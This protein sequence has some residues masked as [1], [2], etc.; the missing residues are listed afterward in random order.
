MKKIILL[1]MLCCGSLSFL[2]AQSETESPKTFGSNKFM[3]T[4]NGEAVF[5]SDS[6]SANFTNINFK[7]IF[8]WKLSDKLFIESEVEIET[9]DGVA[10]LGLEYV[11]MCYIVNPYL[12]FHMGRFLP[13]FGAYRG[14]LGEAYINRFATNPIGFGD[15]GIGPM[16]EVGFGAQGGVPLGSAKMNY[17]LW[18]SNGPQ[19]GKDEATGETA[20][21]SFDYEA[22]SDNNKN[23]ALGGRIGILPFSNSSLEL[24]FSYENAQKTGDSYSPFED[25]S[26]NMMAVDLNYFHTIIAI[27]STVR[28]I[29][30]WK[31]QDEKYPAV[32]PTASYK[33][34]SS[35]YYG[36]ISIRPSVL[37]NKF[38]RN[39]ELAYRYSQF[40]L[41]KVK[42][43]NE[44]A[45]LNK[46]DRM[47]VALDYWFKWNCV[48]KVMWQK[49]KDFTNQYLVQ[50]V[51]GF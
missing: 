22:Y 42:L 37:E 10:D 5:T 15:G 27:K 21:G 38:L 9:G 51:Y 7:P 35:T 11:N 1:V 50:V 46:P 49:E 8:L 24:G 13:K 47:A 33:S 14:K 32:D 18:V 48:L 12:V 44:P 25:V 20:P 26:L 43:D 30:E 16:D 39:L 40:D 17:D 31:M 23:K 2:V 45:G 29:G 41:T 28:L 19:V 3:L 6:G 34:S 4:G 36:T